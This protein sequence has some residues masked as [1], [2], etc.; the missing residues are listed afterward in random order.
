MAGDLERVIHSQSSQR[1]EA[2]SGWGSSGAVRVGVWERLGLGLGDRDQ[3]SITTP[4]VRRPGLG[5]KG[6]RVALAV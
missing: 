4:L 6:Q 2:A 3:S 5:L 1:R